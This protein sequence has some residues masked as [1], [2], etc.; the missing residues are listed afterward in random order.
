[1]VEVTIQGTDIAVEPCEDSLLVLRVWDN[2]FRWNIV[3]D[4]E[5]VEKLVSEV[6][7]L[8]AA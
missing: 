1:M 8:Q 7:L 2:S 5:T 6:E 3:L 4:R